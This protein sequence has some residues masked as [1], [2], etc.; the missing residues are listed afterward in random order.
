MSRRG[1]GSWSCCGSSVDASPLPGAR[2]SVRPRVKVLH[3]RGGCR[4]EPGPLGGM[5]GAAAPE[6]S[7]RCLSFLS[8][9][10]RLVC[11][12]LCTTFQSTKLISRCEPFG[13]SL[14][15][16]LR[17]C[18]SNAGGTGFIPDRETINKIPNAVQCGQKKQN[19]ILKKRCEP[20]D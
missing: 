17:L 2:P 14:V 8:L 20:F 10:L 5:G 3:P 15:Q 13:N 11:P 4:A 1:F 19:E 18:A 7:A 12:P 6:G 16:S 9:F